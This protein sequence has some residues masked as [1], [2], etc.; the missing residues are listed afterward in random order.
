MK[1]VKLSRRNWL[2]S[3]LMLGAGAALSPTAIL[4]GTKGYNQFTGEYEFVGEANGLKAKLNANENP[5]GPSEKALNAFVEA[6]KDGN[7]YPFEYAKE[8]R[9]IIATEEGVTPEHIFLGSGSSEIL[10]MA[11]LAYGAHQGALM[12]AFPTFRTML[13]TAVGIGCDWQ[14]VPLD[15]NQKH[16]LQAM[17]NGIDEA[18]KLVY[19]CN[20][21]NPTG[22]VVDANELRRFCKDVSQNVPVFVDEAY[23]DFMADPQAISMIDTIHEGHN[24]IIARTFSKIHGMAGLRI[25]YGIAQPETAKKIIAWATEL[26]TVSGP[27]LHAAMASYKDEDFKQLCRSKNKAARDYTFKALQELGFAPVE[28]NTSFMIFPINME[29]EQYLTQMTDEGVAVRSWVFAG[30]NWCRV[31]IGTAGEMKSFIS[32]L[33]KVHKA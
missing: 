30:K 28:S 20:P 1:T 17:R 25:G 31:S 11:G 4:A 23:T 18:T 13:D 32:V 5:Y 27:S 15:K 10:T 33:Q 29:P 9:A 21:N 2:K 22:T 14:Q 16:D 12:S 26:I 19:I 24:V 7:L 8:V 3:G 6:A